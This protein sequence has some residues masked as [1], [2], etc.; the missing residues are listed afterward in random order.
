[1]KAACLAALDLAVSIEPGTPAVPDVRWS[2]RPVAAGG[3][4]I[5]IYF[6]AK[7]ITL[8]SA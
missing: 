1:V 3:E 6:L 4:F 2:T 5:A 8:P 7:V